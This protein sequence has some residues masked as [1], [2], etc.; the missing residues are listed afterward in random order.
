MHLAVGIS[1]FPISVVARIAVE[2]VP[3]ATFGIVRDVFESAL[4]QRL[5]AM[6]LKT[7]DEA[8]TL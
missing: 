3:A 8:P 5:N 6:T 7:C 4:G 1:S 2:G